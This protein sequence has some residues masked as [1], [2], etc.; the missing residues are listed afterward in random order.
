MMRKRVGIKTGD[1]PGVIRGKFWERNWG[2]WGIIRA[3]SVY[4]RQLEI[5]RKQM[6]DAL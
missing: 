6:R 5:F 2:G 1:K 4:E 3:A